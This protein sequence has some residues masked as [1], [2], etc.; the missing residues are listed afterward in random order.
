MN[1]PKAPGRRGMK[2]VQPQPQ[3]QTQTPN[4]PSPGKGETKNLQ[5]QNEPSITRGIFKQVKEGFILTLR[6]ALVNIILSILL[7]LVLTVP[8]LV[9]SRTLMDDSS[10]LEAGIPE[11]G[12]LGGI[13]DMFAGLFGGAKGEEYFHNKQLNH[14]LR[15]YENTKMQQAR[16]EAERDGKPWY[17]PEV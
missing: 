16:K 10:K 2:N 3:T 12:I 6:G 14:M 5:E 9:L 1:R 15:N 8:I 4:K 11:V 13:V 17:G 7:F